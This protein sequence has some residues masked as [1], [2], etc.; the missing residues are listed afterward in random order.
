MTRK[1]LAVLLSVIFLAFGGVAAI[2]APAQAHNVYHSNLDY[3]WYKYKFKFNGTKWNPRKKVYGCNF[4]TTTVTDT[5]SG[6]DL[7]SWY[8]NSKGAFKAWVRPN[9][10]SQNQLEKVCFA[11]T[12]GKYY[13][14]CLTILVLPSKPLKLIPYH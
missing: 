9:P 10:V 3:G 11:Q 5:C 8:P 6:V 7:G 2:A 14:K 1:F 4:A 13:L 12:D